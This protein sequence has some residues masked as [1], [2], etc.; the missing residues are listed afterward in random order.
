MEEEDDEGVLVLEKEVL[1]VTSYG[2]DDFDNFYV[3]KF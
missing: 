2:I 1:L 3:D